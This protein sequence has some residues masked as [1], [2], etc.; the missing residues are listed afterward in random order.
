MPS[1]E[2]QTRFWLL[3]L[4]ILLVSIFVI[5]NLNKFNKKCTP[6]TV[7]NLKNSIPH[8][9]S[10]RPN[11]FDSSSSQSPENK[12]EYQSEGLKTIISDVKNIPAKFSYQYRLWPEGSFLDPDNYAF[13]S[14]YGWRMNPPV[15]YPQKTI[16]TAYNKA[17]ENCLCSPQEGNE[18]CL[19]K[20]RFKAIYAQGFPSIFSN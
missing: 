16:G 12:I 15:Q 5:T 13:Y 6:S 2:S 11:D 14:M 17:I 19:E 4:I 3:F 7:R 1:Q 8:H 20:C 9:L 10:I 18:K